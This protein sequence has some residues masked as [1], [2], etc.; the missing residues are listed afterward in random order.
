MI[1]LQKNLYLPNQ[2]EQKQAIKTAVLLRKAISLISMQTWPG[3]RY[4][5]NTFFQRKSQGPQKTDFRKFF[6]KAEMGSKPETHSID[7]IRSL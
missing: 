4:S 6:P 2:Q 5:K 3:R 1:S 7:R